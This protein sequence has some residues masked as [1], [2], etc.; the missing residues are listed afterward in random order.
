MLALSAAVSGLS[1]CGFM[2]SFG[3]LF[4]LPLILGIVAFAAADGAEDPKRAKI[5]SVVGAVTGL[6]LAAIMLLFIV[7]P[8]SPGL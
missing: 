8:R 5:L 6:V 3:L 7:G 4:F 1:M 2:A